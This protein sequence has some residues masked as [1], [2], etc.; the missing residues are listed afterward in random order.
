MVRAEGWSEK[1]GSKWKTMPD[2]MFIYRAAAFWQRAYAPE[3]GMGLSTAEELHDIVDVDSQGNVTLSK[4]SAK[5]GRIINQET[6]EI[7]SSLRTVIPPCTEE[8]FEAQKDGWKGIVESGKKTA[9]DLIAMV[10]TT[11]ILGD[12]QKIE[13]ASWETFITA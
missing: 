12:D 10:Q 4:G 5:Q 6:G 11:E 2:Q 3:V 1:K 13:I 8:S 9:N 7:S